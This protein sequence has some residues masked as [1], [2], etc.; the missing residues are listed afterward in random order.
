RGGYR[1]LEQSH[2]ASGQRLGRH[3][4]EL[5]H[6][7][8]ESTF[9]SEWLLSMTQV[10]SEVECQIEL[11]HLRFDGLGASYDSQPKLGSFS[12][13]QRLHFAMQ[14]QHDLEQRIARR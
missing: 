2:E 5:V 11:R 8:D 10:I 4:L 12:S 14:C 6:T 7:E 9:D 3:S 1:R 13:L